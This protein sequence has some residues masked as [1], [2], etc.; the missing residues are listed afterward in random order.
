MR[1]ATVIIVA[2]LA[3]VC[4]EDDDLH[5][6]EDIV[7]FVPPNCPCDSLDTCQPYCEHGEFLADT[8]FRV[9]ASPGYSCNRIED[10][11]CSVTQTGDFE[12]TIQ[13]SWREGPPAQSCGWTGSEDVCFSQ[14]FD[15]GEAPPL[16]E[17]T[18]TVHYADISKPFVVPG[19]NALNP[20]AEDPWNCFGAASDASTGE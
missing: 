10:F 9:A 4:V 15:C 3:I 19:S 12:L 14:T 1:R 8:S 6:D 17:G 7:C 18:W 5:V 13:S 20:S 16:A 2:A 11:E